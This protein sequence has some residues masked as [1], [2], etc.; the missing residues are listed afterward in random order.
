MKRIN[1]LI[2]IAII[3]IVSALFLLLRPT[4]NKVEKE[5][6]EDMVVIYIDGKQLIEKS[7]LGEHFSVD[8]RRF[9]ASL[10]T[11]SM[12][13]SEHIISIAV[14]PDNSGLWFSR[15][16][17]AYANHNEKNEFDIVAIIEVNDINRLDTTMQLL[18]SIAESEGVVFDLK[19]VG[20]TRYVSLEGIECGY[21]KSHLAIAI[22]EANTTTLLQTALT[23]P[24]S[25]LSTFEGHDTAM[26]INLHKLL[27]NNLKQ[28]TERIAALKENIANNTLSYEV[29]LYKAQI[30]PLEEQLSRLQNMYSTLNNDASLLTTLNFEDGNIRLMT[31]CNGVALPTDLMREV[32]NSHLSYIDEE[33]IAIANYGV[34]GKSLAQII[35]DNIPTD[36][37]SMLGIGRNEFNMGLQ[38]ALDA[39][40]SINGDITIA[41]NALDGGIQERYNSYRRQSYKSIEVENIKALLITD[42]DDSYI[43][44]NV[45]RFGGNMLNHNEDGSLSLS[46]A[47]NIKLNAGHSDHLFYTGIN[48]TLTDSPNPATHTKWYNDVNHSCG[49]TVLNI[50]SMLYSSYIDATYND[51]LKTLSKSDAELMRDIISSLDYAYHRL[52]KDYTNE[53][54][55]VLKNRDVN[56]LKQLTNL[57]IPYTMQQAKSQF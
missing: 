22:S 4:D 45:N 5:A 57:F 20:D 33:V 17:Y 16:I 37:A 8:N 9:I 24:L 3:A 15:P 34:N 26:Y 2:I 35:G 54:V 39:V 47:K 46:I 12:E 49:Y 38:I 13:H 23:R 43:F 6:I 52:D 55:L 53:L 36:M 50:N 18:D 7:G 19:Q 10:A 56:A 25:D 41:L 21:N 31:S 40:S 27:D 11:G 42:V 32:N 1:P 30:T 48:T 51:W 14:N 28:T 29:E 44:D